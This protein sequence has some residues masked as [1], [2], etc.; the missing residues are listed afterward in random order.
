MWLVLAFGNMLT[1]A[2]LRLIQKQFV[3]QSKLNFF[4]LNWIMAAFGIPVFVAIIYSQL[5]L[6]AD[7][8]LIFWAVLF[9]VVIGFYPAVTYLYFKTIKE[10]QLSEVL[11]LMGL[12]P[13]ATLVF[14][15]VILGQKPTTTGVLGVLLIS[16]SIYVLQSGRNSHWL[17]PFKNIFR[18]GP[19]RN[20][21]IISIITAAA[22][23]GDKYAIDASSTAI[24]FALNGLGAVIIL[25]ICDAVFS[26]NRDRTTAGKSLSISRNRVLMMISMGA[27]LLATQ[28]LGFAAL[29][30][31]PVAGYAV[32]IR[33]LNIVVASLAALAVLNEPVT[34]NK[35][36]CY[37]ISAIGVLLI[38][39]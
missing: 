10:N 36:I 18:S 23:I 35:I 7:L 24:Y 6:I 22:A 26:M 13:I 2:A 19:S 20:M 3:D 21:L 11:P 17:A 31:A 32:G 38:A 30:I 4:R 29:S 5:Q 12:I 1:L 27:L 28:L 39:L 9:A 33:N 25:L 34:R 8:T 37:G 16:I 14:G 15:W